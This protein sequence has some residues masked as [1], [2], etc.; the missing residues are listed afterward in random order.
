MLSCPLVTQ[1]PPGTCFTVI[2]VE[3]KLLLGSIYRIVI[4]QEKGPL[5]IK[6]QISVFLALLPDR[7]PVYLSKAFAKIIWGY[8]QDNT[9]ISRGA[10][11]HF[12]RG[13]A[14]TMAHNYHQHHELWVF[15]L[16]CLQ[17]PCRR[18]SLEAGNAKSVELSSLENQENV[19]LV[20]GKTCPCLLLQN[21]VCYILR[22]LL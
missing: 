3:Q 7:G 4:S 13:Q 16:R 17:I 1:L 15:A 6:D 22:A 20:P 5:G 8:H 2:L 9:V 19:I 11:W 12:H 18:H 10:L 21:V 14:G